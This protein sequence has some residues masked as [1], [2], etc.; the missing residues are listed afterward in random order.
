MSYLAELVITG[1]SLGATYG[2]VALGFVV[3]FRATEVVNF[4]YG[5]MVL[6][7]AYVCARLAESAPFALAAAGGIAASVT[8]GLLVDV[9]ILRR[10]SHGNEAVLAIVTLGVD[11]VLLTELARRLG[12]DVL[13]LGDPF[14]AATVELAGVT[15]PQTRLAAI[16]V[17]AAALLAFFAAL[18]YSRWGVAMRAAA[19]DRVTAALMGISPARVSAGAWAAAGV[20]AA[21]AGLVLAAFPS[22]G[23]DASLR[24]SAFVAFPAA[25]LGGLDSPPG[26]VLGGVIV[27]V[28]ATLVAGYQEHFL[29]LGRDLAAITPFVVMIAVLL[30]R[31]SGL[32]GSRE[33]GRV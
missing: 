17:A 11:I 30:W 21:I 18:R 8:C 13:S 16:A 33:V 5:S 20:F 14:G 19:E 15:V 31:P 25:I 1:V 2:L 32:M 27:G 12:T 29:F 9:L 22:P 28:T 23:V 4:A 10:A 26:A 3:V 24:I 6:L 7:G